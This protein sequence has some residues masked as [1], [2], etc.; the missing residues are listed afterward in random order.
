MRIA[1]VERALCRPSKCGT[2]C[3]RFCPI[4]RSGAKCVWVD[5]E[6]KIARID[7]KLCVGC[8]ICVKK[9]PF[10]AIHIVNL[11]EKLGSELVHRYGL[12]GFELFRLPIPK[13]G[14]VIGIIGSNGVGKSTSLKILAGEL[15]PN[16][17]NVNE[18][19]S[20][21]TIIKFFRGSELQPYFQKLSEGRIK[22]VRKPQEID[23]IPRYVKG[24]VRQIIEKIDERGVAC[25]LKERLALDRVW[26]REVAYLSGGELQK[27][28]I[29]ATMCR[30]ADVYMFDE[31]SSYLDVRERLRVARSIRVLATTGKYVVVVEH[32]L[33][34]LDYLC[35]LVHVLY[36]E[37]G[38]Y[39]IVSLP[40]GVRVG[41]NTFLKGVLKEENI[42]FREYEI[43]FHVK[44]PERRN[45]PEAVVV[46]WDTLY[47][48][49]GTFELT[50]EAGEIYAGEVVGVVGP[51]G[52]GKSTFVKMLV[53]ELQPDGGGVL[54]GHGLKIS[55]K[56]QVISRL[57]TGGSVREVLV[58]A[59]VDTG[60]SFV[61]SELLLPLSVNKF[62]ERDISELSGGELQRVAIAVA[63]GKEAEVYLLDEPMAY[64]DIEQRYAVARVIKHLTEDRGAATLVVEHDLVAQDFLADSIMVFSGEPG[65]R[66]FSS[67]PLSMREGFNKLLEDLDVTFRRDPDT[68]R[69]RVNKEGSRLD[70]YLKGI[71]EYYYSLPLEEDRE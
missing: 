26:D 4:N 43:K 5:E 13:M 18:D 41:I 48:K 50:V 9:C 33:A 69:P 17:G 27:L 56:P 10:S 70:R 53:G 67:P 7:E 35:D 38:A 59:G 11:P 3:V 66:G 20:W 61:Q 52:I 63:L 36:G 6:H 47:K 49:L 31:P 34:V 16:L 62:M 60:S 25:E 58:K 19:C 1:I 15:K 57:E 46:K 23:V 2:E 40:R 39:G 29:A 71:K 12:N 14:Q 22:T 44:P 55:Y 37:P 64:L 32:D 51:N 28:A 45:A 68:L 30:E 65:D 54:V 8:G 21:D 24:T 42:R